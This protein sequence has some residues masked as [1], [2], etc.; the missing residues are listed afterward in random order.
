MTHN[1]E[2]RQTLSRIRGLVGSVDGCLFD[3]PKDFSPEVI[4]AVDGALRNME[5]GLQQ[6]LGILANAHDPQAKPEFAAAPLS[7]EGL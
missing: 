5:A 7:C 3:A 2:A 1:S 4:G 6:V